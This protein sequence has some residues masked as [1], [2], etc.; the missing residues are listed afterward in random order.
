MISKRKNV[1]D[2]PYKIIFAWR[3]A[4]AGSESSQKNHTKTNP[5]MIITAELIYNK[6]QCFNNKE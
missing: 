1:S 4:P 6:P 5:N 2:S 3:D